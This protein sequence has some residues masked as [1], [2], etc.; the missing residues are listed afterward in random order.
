MFRPRM[1]KLPKTVWR[2]GWVSLLTDVASDMAYP[3][4]PAFLATMGA[5]GVWLGWVEG[6]AESVSA[7]VKYAAGASSDRTPAR[8]PF[9]VFGYAVSSL[10]RPV[11]ALVTA[12]W[13]VVALRT[14][15]RIGKGVRSAPRDALLAAAITPE[16]RAYAFG[17]HRMMDNVGAVVGPL[18][19]FVLA[20]FAHW[21]MRAIF[22]FAIVPGILAVAVLVFGVKETGHPPETK[23]KEEGRAPLDATVK[24]YLFAIG[25][26]S[27]GASSDSFLLLRLSRQHLAVAFLPIA[28]LTLNA[29]KA[30]T[31]VGGGRL[32]DRVGRRT[33]VFAGWLL[34]AAVYAV[35]PLAHTWA[36]TWA[37]MLG[38]GFYY[39]LTEGAERALLTDVAPKE[40]RGRA[41]GALHAI[42]GAAV[43][44]ANAVFGFIFDTHPNVAFLLGAGFA[45]LGALALLAV[46]PG[47]VS[48]GRAA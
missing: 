21:S 12:P 9:V 42:T 19:A 39:G 30:L 36:E 16:T 27:L 44:P 22:A 13:Q 45:A 14:T 28:W 43:L 38:Y 18:L 5:A 10:V 41:F 34:Y 7:F 15:D 46:R 29:T 3:L 8:K 48:A 20:D 6:V 32:A 33:T 2:L 26:F 31:N 17:F 25:I 37:V 40:Q 23:K 35:L 4:L 24:R 11:L 1:P 47:S